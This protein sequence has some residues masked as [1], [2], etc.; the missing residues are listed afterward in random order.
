MVIMS[1][2]MSVIRC[3]L[4]VVNRQ[5]SWIFSTNNLSCQNSSIVPLQMKSFFYIIERSKVEKPPLCWCCLKSRI[6]LSILG[7]KWSLDF[8]REFMTCISASFSISSNESS[9]TLL[10]E[11]TLLKWNQAKNC[12]ETG[13]CIKVLIRAKCYGKVM[14]WLIDLSLVSINSFQFLKVNHHSKF[15]FQISET[16]LGNFAVF[17]I[18]PHSV[19]LYFLQSLNGWALHCG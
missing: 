4:L 8:T 17:K 12:I 7:Q 15:R 1:D 6:I 9:V 16:H 19:Q 5:S 18:D 14:N 13:K 2:F 10:T 11:K 3:K